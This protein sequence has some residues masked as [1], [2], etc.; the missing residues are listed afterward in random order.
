VHKWTVP[1]LMAST[2]SFFIWFS[3]HPWPSRSS[4]GFFKL[5]GWDFGYCGHC[6]LIVL[7]PDDRRKLTPAPLCPPQIPHDYTKYCYIS[8]S[9]ELGKTTQSQF[10]IA[11]F[12]SSTARNRPTLNVTNPPLQFAVRIST[13]LVKFNANFFRF[14]YTLRNYSFHNNDSLPR[15]FVEYV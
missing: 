7:A 9:K 8:F 14:L 12:R 13:M 15:N 6:W 3:S 11:A 10:M 2:S 4:R 5:V 1:K